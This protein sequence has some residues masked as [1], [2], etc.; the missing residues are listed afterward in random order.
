[1]SRR[2]LVSYLSVTLLVLAVLEVP[3][4]VTYGRNERSDLETKVERDA[5][6]L[7]SLSEGVLEGTAETPLPAL[8]SIARRYQADTGGRVV[9]AGGAVEHRRHPPRECDA[10]SLAS[11]LRKAGPHPE[12]GVAPA[13]IDRAV[14]FPA[15]T[16]DGSA[17]AWV[18]RA[19]LVMRPAR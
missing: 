14:T 9:V 1:M 17:A 6:T 13:P 19:W 18:A 7:A 2:L 12:A 3:L 15:F 16:A 11:R 8:R 4:G 10:S 5:V